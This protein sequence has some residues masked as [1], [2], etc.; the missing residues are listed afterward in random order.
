MSG[1]FVPT[2][3][4]ASVKVAYFATETGIN[5]SSINANTLTIDGDGSGTGIS[6][7][8]NADIIFA[9][10]ATVGA[11]AMAIANFDGNISTLAGVKTPLSI[12]DYGNGTY[13]TTQVGGLIV[14]GS[15]TSNTASGS[16]AIIDGNNTADLSIASRVLDL[17]VSSIT[18]TLGNFVQFE[19]N[20]FVRPP[21]GQTTAGGSVSIVNG[22]G[23]SNFNQYSLT[24]NGDGALG[25]QLALTRFQGVSSYP[26]LNIDN[27]GNMLF[28]DPGAIVYAD[29]LSTIALQAGSIVVPNQG[30]SLVSSGSPI[31]S[32]SLNSGAT[33]ANIDFAGSVGEFIAVTTGGV[34]SLQGTLAVTGSAGLSR[35]FTVNVVSTDGVTAGLSYPIY[36]ATNTAVYSGTGALAGVQIPICAVFKATDNKVS[37]SCACPTITGAET[38]DFAMSV[39]T[40]SRLV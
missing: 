36:N 11:N 24:V 39:T 3:T 16:F 2:A 7:L 14:S 34:Y 22:A 8:N 12:Y 10:G 35:A 25:G 4:R 9:D 28:K 15:A 31:P 6:M 29:N 18:N 26:V 30:R 17:Q 23:C 37:V 1:T 38:L 40:I 5:V 27:D 33:V 21:I 19:E 20:L 32:A 13:G